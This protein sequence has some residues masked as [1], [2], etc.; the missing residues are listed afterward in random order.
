MQIKHYT[1]PIFIPELACPFQCI[2][3]NQRKTSRQLT[4]PTKKQ[5]QQII[6]DNLTTIPSQ[7]NIIEL[8]FFG[9]NFTGIALEKQ[10]ELLQIV[11]PYLESKKI[12]SIRIST[13]PD[14]IND[15]ILKLLKKH[16]V[17]T[18]ELGAQSFDEEVLKLSKRGH[19]T[20]DTVN[21]SQMILNN[22]FSLGLQMMIGLPGDTLKR[23]IYTATKIAELG[24]DNTRIYPCLVIKGTKLEKLYLNNEYKPLSIEEAVSRSKEILKIFEQNGVNVI[25]MGLHPSEGILNRTELVAGPFHNSFRELVLTE[26]WNDML[27]PLFKFQKVRKCTIFVPSNQLNYA[28]GYKSKNK[29]MLY[30]YF[31]KVNFKKDSSLK[32]REFYVDNN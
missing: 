17:K 25:R 11:H 19:T 26:I 5:V 20:D 2:F 13:R 8:G 6:Q 18:I 10:E 21:A 27:K 31:E 32:G 9:G 23:A 15:N 4:V 29:K 22:G 1:I 3:C 28:I 16:Y 7:N 12:S 30:Q 24:A 14:Y